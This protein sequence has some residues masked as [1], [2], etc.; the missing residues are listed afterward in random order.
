MERSE[1]RM[2]SG[3]SR[4]TRVGQSEVR[5]KSD[6]EQTNARGTER[7]AAEYIELRTNTRHT[8]SNGKRML[9][10]GKLCAK[11]AKPLKMLHITIGP[12]QSRRGR[13]RWAGRRRA[14]AEEGS[15]KG[16]PRE[17]PHHIGRATYIG[18]PLPTISDLQ[19]MERKSANEIIG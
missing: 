16:K 14:R 1:I 5:M 11:L 9:V 10:C 8:L 18:A 17:A 7:Y 13:P 2:K 15:E 3:K 6:K 19:S 4:R 12:S